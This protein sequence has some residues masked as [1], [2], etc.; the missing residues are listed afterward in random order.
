[1]NPL[2]QMRDKI[3]TLI[4]ESAILAERNRIMREIDEA[5]LPLGV[6]PLIEKI[7]NPE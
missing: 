4:R 1:M 6:W 2:E 7:I 5:N 3:E